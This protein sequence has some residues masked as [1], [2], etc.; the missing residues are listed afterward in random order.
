[1]QLVIKTIQQA[2]Q[3][4]KVTDGLI[5]HSDQGQQYSSHPYYVL[6]HQYNMTQSMS[7]PG[8]V[9]DNAPMENFIGHLKEEAMRRIKN[10]TFNRQT[11]RWWLYLLLQLWKDTI[12][13]ETDTLSNQVPV[14]LT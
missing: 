4:E 13:N 5:L 2:L 12:E 11:N 1:M 6:T 9:W 8:N 14:W 7:R 3:K 10:P